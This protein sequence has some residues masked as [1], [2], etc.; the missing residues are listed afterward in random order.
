MYACGSSALVA[1]EAEV[2]DPEGKK[3]H[4]PTGAPVFVIIGDMDTLVKI[5]DHGKSCQ[6]AQVNVFEMIDG[7]EW[8]YE[9]YDNMT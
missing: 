8:H 3:K 7:M 6:L 2:D 5:K 1:S 4:K 9:R